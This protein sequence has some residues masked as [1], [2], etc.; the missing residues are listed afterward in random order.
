[1]LNGKGIAFAHCAAHYIRGTGEVHEWH[2]WLF[3]SH[4]AIEAFDR[5]DATEIGLAGEYTLYSDS[6]ALV[7]SPPSVAVGDVFA[8]EYS[9]DEDALLAAWP[10]TFQGLLPELS[11]TLT[12][13]APHGIEPIVKLFATDTVTT[14][15]EGDRWSWSRV[16]LRPLPD[17][18]LAPAK[19]SAAPSIVIELAANSSAASMGHSFSDWSQV[20]TW[21]DQLAAPQGQVT[22]EIAARASALS[23]GARDTLERMAAIAHEVQRFNYVSI[24]MGLGHGLGYR[25]N[26]AGDVL[27][28]GY[29]D[30]KDKANLARTLIAAAGGQAWLLAAY[31]GSRDWVES[32]W[33]SPLQF[34]HCIVALRVPRG[35]ALPAAFEYPPLG[36]LLAFD[37]TDPLTPF[38]MLPADEQ[39]SLVLIESAKTTDLVRLPIAP[40]GVDHMERSIAASLDEDG[41]LRGRLVERSRGAAAVRQRSMRRQLSDV[42]FRKQLESWLAGGGGTMKVGNVSCEEDSLAGTFTLSA[43]FSCPLFAK[44]AG[45]RLMTFSP[46]LISATV[47]NLS[48]S[49]R[50]RDIAF[51]GSSFAETV[52]VAIPHGFRVDELPAAIH[53]HRD[54]GS[55][56]AAWTDAGDRIEYTRAWALKAV[57][58]PPERHADVAGLL[59]EN[60]RAHRAPVVLIRP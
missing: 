22:P 59:A 50:T 12:L 55:I 46:A 42:E 5:G 27:R 30:C 36:T 39:G 8:W 49:V 16:A 4:G 48:D 20:A 25:P 41:G 28:L 10:W 34:N 54:F 17:E 47:P 1:M 33:P 13:D 58:L 56:D 23:S 21:L 19:W 26:A 38:G 57:T 43:E 51:E 40:E 24:E 53:D 6:R 9:T 3:H 11:S 45:G 15:R 44:V 60:Q 7:L 32:R 35:T 18:P 14:R 37:P 52:A 2:A 31:S 29:G